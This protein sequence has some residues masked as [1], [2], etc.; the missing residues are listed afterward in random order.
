MNDIS[1]RYS[2]TLNTK[3][4]KTLSSDQLLFN[5]GDDVTIDISIIEDNVN[6]N[7][8]QAKVDLLLLHELDDNP[9]IHR[10]EDGGINISDNVV[11]ILCKNS[12]INKLGVSVCQ[13]IIRD[14]NQSITTQMFS[15]K[16][17]NTLI[18][19]EMINASEKIDTLVELDK[20]IENCKN[21]IL[22]T[23][24][25][26]LDIDNK[27]NQLVSKVENEILS[28]NSILREVERAEGE[29]VITFDQIKRDN[30]SLKSDVENT[31]ANVQDGVTPNITIGNVTTLDPGVPATV[32]RRGNDD[33]PIFD[34]GIPKGI[35]GIT[36]DMTKFENKINKQ[37][38]DINTKNNEF[39]DQMNT[40]FGNAKVGYDG[41]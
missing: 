2:I 31:I 20:T 3:G 19:D 29:R 32:V 8:S 33:S 23:S 13:L 35:D 7:L 5:H 14:E 27:T 9:V 34:F 21:K 30:E 6:K 39:K 15:Y 36:P 41:R 16:T 24:N 40:D 22:E 37:Y 10:F 1:K 25:L 4:N 28:A 18:S 17:N 38:E 12:Y 26:L 11:T